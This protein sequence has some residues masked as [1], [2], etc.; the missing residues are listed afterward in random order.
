MEGGALSSVRQRNATN[1]PDSTTAERPGPC[2]LNPRCSPTHAPA[3]GRIRCWPSGPARAVVKRSRR[4]LLE[5]VAR[6][7]HAA[8]AD[9][10]P[11]MT[12]RGSRRRTE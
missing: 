8:L 2:A 4:V 6:T 7:A 12:A 11:E 9:G 10:E 1:I 3:S 5:N